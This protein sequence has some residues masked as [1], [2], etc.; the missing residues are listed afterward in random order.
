MAASDDDDDDDSGVLRV[1]ITLISADIAG[2]DMDGFIVKDD[3]SD[4]IQDASDSDHSDSEAEE[5]EDDRRS[6]KGK[7]ADSGKHKNQYAGQKKAVAVPK[8]QFSESSPVHC[9]CS[10]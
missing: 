9:A 6:R 3:D 4:T 8:F 5:S 10:Y 2:A 7:K 1:S